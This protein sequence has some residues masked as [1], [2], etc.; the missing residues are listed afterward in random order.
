MNLT[1]KAI[2]FMCGF[3]LHE[4]W[5][6]VDRK[7]TRVWYVSCR[8]QLDIIDYDIPRSTEEHKAA[9]LCCTY[10]NLIEKE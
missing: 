6:M 4:R 10:H 5:E 2:A 7:S 8:N 9:E 1:H 3:H